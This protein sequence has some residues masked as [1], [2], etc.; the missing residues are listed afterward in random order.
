MPQEDTRTDVCCDV[1]GKPAVG[2]PSLQDV[3]LTGCMTCPDLPPAIDLLTDYSIQHIL[4]RI[5]A[6]ATPATHLWP[7]SCASCCAAP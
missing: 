3:P 6:S 4:D 7:T 1:T 5:G 2:L